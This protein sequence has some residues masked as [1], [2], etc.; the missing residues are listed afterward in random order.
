MTIPSQEA[1][2]IISEVNISTVSKPLPPPVNTDWIKTESSPG[3][4]HNGSNS[5]SGGNPDLPARPPP[6]AR[7]PS[8]SAPNSRPGRPPGGRPP[9]GQF[10]A[11]PSAPSTGHTP[12]PSPQMWNNNGFP[13]PQPPS[14]PQPRVM[15]PP[16]VA[17]SA[18][19]PP[20]RNPGGGKIERRG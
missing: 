4:N 5:S 11:A 2:D 18:F 8:S 9:S 6:L 7:Q 1:L 12:S 13:A 20:Q 19:P 17:P 10:T 16:P 3:L 15:P 14:Q